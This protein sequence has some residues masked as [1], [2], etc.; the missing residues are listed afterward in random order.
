MKVLKP[1]EPL[2]KFSWAERS[3]GRTML[4]AIL[5]WEVSVDMIIVDN[6]QYFNVLPIALIVYI[7]YMNDLTE[8]PINVS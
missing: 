3:I 6:Y 5:V 2:R 8:L 4:L 1:Y 7:N